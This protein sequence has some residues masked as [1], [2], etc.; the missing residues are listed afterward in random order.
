AVREKRKLMVSTATVAL[1][2]QL[3]RDLEKLAVVA[4]VKFKHKVLKGRARYVCD[5]DLAH[6]GGEDEAQASLGLGD[7]IAPAWTFK[8]TKQEIA[9]THRMLEARRR[10]TWDGDMDSWKDPIPERIRPLITTTGAG[11]SGQSCQH[12]VRCPYHAAKRGWVDADV[13]VVNHALLLADQALGS[14][15][16]LP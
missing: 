12:M 14:G 13:L 7:A 9:T 8:P 10:K 2:R 1:Q 4:P 3:E 16:L 15:A 6:L 5:R 11:C